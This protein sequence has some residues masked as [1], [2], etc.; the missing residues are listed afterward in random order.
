MIDD[1]LIFIGT[2]YGSTN[3]SAFID[4]FSFIG[5]QKP[6]MSKITKLC[7]CLSWIAIKSR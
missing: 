7:R 1:A 4:N 3:F 6:L 2:V 5:G